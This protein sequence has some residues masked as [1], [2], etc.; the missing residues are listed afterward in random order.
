VDDGHVP[1]A[2]PRLRRRPRLR[3]PRGLDA[4]TGGRGGRFRFPDF[5]YNDW[6]GKDLLGTNKYGGFAAF[7]GELTIWTIVDVFE[8]LAFY[9]MVFDFGVGFF[10]EWASA[11]A[12][13]KYCHARD[14][15]VLLAD[16]PGYPLQGIFGWDAMGILDAVKMRK[17][18]FFNGFGASLEFGPGQA[19][20][21]C[22][23]IAAGGDPDPWIEMRLRCLTGPRTGYIIMDHIDVAPLGHAQIGVQC[24]IMGQE[25]WIAEI[26]VNGGW[27]INGPTL[28]MH[29]VA[30]VPFQ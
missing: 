3:R 16:A 18:Q 25:V 21:S 22:Q 12:Q 23:G 14:D 9:F 2:C 27:Q 24:A 19:A 28:N 4:R 26:R 6:L 20:A 5:D 11:V 30:K 1:H 7:P 29:A 17:V 15:A 8:R 10:Y 13:T